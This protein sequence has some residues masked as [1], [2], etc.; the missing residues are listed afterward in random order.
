MQTVIMDD[1]GNERGHPM[2]VFLTDHRIIFILS[3]SHPQVIFESSKI[4]SSM[5]TVIMDD[6]GKERGMK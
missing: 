5:Q 6:D 4:K 1:G 3:L 2:T